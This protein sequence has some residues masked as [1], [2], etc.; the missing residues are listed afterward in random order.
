MNPSVGILQGP[1][2]GQPSPHSN[3]NSVT[4][5]YC[6]SILVHIPVMRNKDTLRVLSHMPLCSAPCFAYLDSLVFL[7]Y[8]KVLEKMAARYIKLIN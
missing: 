5:D 8:V 4:K 7:R 3:N 6:W 1:L 2:L